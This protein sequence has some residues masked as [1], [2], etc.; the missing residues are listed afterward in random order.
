MI[1]WGDVLFYGT[2]LVTGIVRIISNR[3]KPGERTGMHK[4]SEIGTI[5][6]C[7]FAA[8]V[9]LLTFLPDGDFKRLISPVAKIAAVGALVI[10]LISVV[11]LWR[12]RKDNEE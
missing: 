12:S 9:L 4:L 8:L 1:D 3:K 10:M 5:L 2:F 6:Y 11:P 7:V